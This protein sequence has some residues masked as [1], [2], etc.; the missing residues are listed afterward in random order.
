MHVQ[1]GKPL[2]FYCL[3]FSRG[4]HVYPVSRYWCKN[5]LGVTDSLSRISR[6]CMMR[7]VWWKEKLI[8]LH[9]NIFCS[10]YTACYFFLWERRVQNHYFCVSFLY[11]FTTRNSSVCS[12]QY[13]ANHRFFSGLL[14]V[15][16]NCMKEKRTRPKFGHKVQ[17]L[18]AVTRIHEDDCR[19]GGYTPKVSQN[20]PLFY[21]RVGV[22]FPPHVPPVMLCRTVPSCQHKKWPSS[23]SAIS[24]EE[25]VAFSF[26]LE[27]STL[28]RC[29]CRL[30]YRPRRFSEGSSQS[31]LHCRPFHHC[32]RGHDWRPPWF[33]WS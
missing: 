24:P 2:F 12:A 29:F 9:T 15:W 30:F 28:R 21:I 25:R 26:S 4:T 8:K 19:Y 20:C 3:C 18:P 7:Y 1:K 16:G 33:L 10:A 11:Q 22:G 32:S 23:F 14:E 31:E 27:K 6:A 17:S 13:I 5:S